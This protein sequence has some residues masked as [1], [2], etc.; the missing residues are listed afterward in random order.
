MC[1]DKPGSDDDE[2]QEHWDKET[3]AAPKGLV[4]GPFGSSLGGK[5]YVDHGVPVIRGGNLSTASTFDV[6]KILYQ[7]LNSKLVRRRA[8]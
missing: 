1:E 7:L 6:C 2:Y 3:V 8:A 5:D 4:G